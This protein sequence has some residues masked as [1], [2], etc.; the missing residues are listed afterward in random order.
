MGSKCIC[1]MYAL[2]EAG[3]FVHSVHDYQ[4]YLCIF[5]QSML[6]AFCYSTRTWTLSFC[7]T[8]TALVYGFSFYFHRS[9]Y[10]LQWHISIHSLVVSFLSFL[11]DTYLLNWWLIGSFPP[12]TQS[13]IVFQN[14][15]CHGPCPSFHCLPECSI[16]WSV[17][18]LGTYKYCAI[19]YY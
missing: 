2:P 4:T 5:V 17:H 11:T 19:L 3:N 13:P 8:F 10:L 1:V 7:C 15:P 12:L 16:P 9:C 18:I 14:V 6:S